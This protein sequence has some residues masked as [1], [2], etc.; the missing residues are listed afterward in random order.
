MMEGFYIRRKRNLITTSSVKLLLSF[1]LF[2]PLN[3]YE[4]NFRIATIMDIVVCVS[5]IIFDIKQLER[6]REKLTIIV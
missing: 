4:A 6:E 2:V 5:I 1:S 3:I